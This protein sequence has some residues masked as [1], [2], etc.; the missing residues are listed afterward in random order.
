MTVILNQQESL[1]SESNKNDC[2]P[3]RSRLHLKPAQSK[4]PQLSS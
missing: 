4:D 1:S 2:H 3:E